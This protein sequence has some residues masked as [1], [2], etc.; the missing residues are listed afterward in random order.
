MILLI[1][2]FILAILGT[3]VALIPPPS[4]WSRFG[5]VLIGVALILVIAKGL[6]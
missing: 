4:E 2:A 1:I 5:V 3:L 6:F